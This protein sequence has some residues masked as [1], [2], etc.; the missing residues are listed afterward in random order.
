MKI[1][2]FFRKPI[3]LGLELNLHPEL[4]ILEIGELLRGR[5]VRQ[6]DLCPLEDSHRQAWPMRSVEH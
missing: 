3:L 2:H 1:V 6:E 5:L 4:D